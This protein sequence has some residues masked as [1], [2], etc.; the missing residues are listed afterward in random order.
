[1]RQSGAFAGGADRDD[2]VAALGD[3]PIDEFLQRAE[4][5]LAVVKRRDKGGHR[6]T[7]HVGL[8]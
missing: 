7:E 5:H 2:A 4:I 8:P 3:M 6:T 1:L